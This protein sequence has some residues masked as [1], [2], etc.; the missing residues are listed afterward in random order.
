MKSIQLQAINI[1]TKNANINFGK[2]DIYISKFNR[3]SSVMNTQNAWNRYIEGN[4]G[5]VPVHA[6]VTL[7]ANG[8]NTSKYDL[9]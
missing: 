6:N 1:P 4:A 5:L 8:S 9:F 7:T 2:S 3:L